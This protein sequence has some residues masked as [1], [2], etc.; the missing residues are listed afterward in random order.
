MQILAKSRKHFMRMAIVVLAA[1]P[2]LH[3]PC[4]RTFAATKEPVAIEDL[5]ITPGRVAA[6]R[7]AA[8]SGGG[9]AVDANGARRRSLHGRCPS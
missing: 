3:A 1:V 8:A 5:R 2:V 7:G 9:V 6:A 4:S